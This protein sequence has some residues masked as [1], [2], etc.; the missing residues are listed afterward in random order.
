LHVSESGLYALIF[1]SRKPEAKRFRLW[2]TSEVLP[3][4]R[5]TGAYSSKGPN[6]LR[7]AAECSE[8]ACGGADMEARA[9]LA[10]ASRP[11]ISVSA[12][13]ELLGRVKLVP[14]GQGVR[15]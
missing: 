4:I 8:P 6:G 13:V 12:L 5:R 9:S 11:E 10:A 7:G 1:K 3:S 2:V 14:D 15:I